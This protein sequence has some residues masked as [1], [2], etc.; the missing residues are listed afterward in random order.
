M[1]S[2][3]S[4]ALAALSACAAPIE[5]PAPQ[6]DAGALAPI[7]EDPRVFVA[8]PALLSRPLESQGDLMP[9]L[10]KEITN[11][12][13]RHGYEVLPTFKF[14]REWE[15]AE[16]RVRGTDERS[17]DALDEREFEACYRETVRALAANHSFTAVVFPVVDYES[18]DL[19]EP[20]R[21]ATWRGVRRKVK[22]EGAPPSEPRT[23][24]VAM[25]L[26]PRV[27][28]RSGVLAYESSIG[29]DIAEK[30]VE[31]DGEF[32]LVA[33]SNDEIDDRSIDECIDLVLGPLVDFGK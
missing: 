6:L 30:S 12:L 28:G 32:E 19:E 26:R 20:Y 7:A 2:L 4:L 27:V 17:S 31:R 11:Y 18:I 9:R 5:P 24:Y 1:R 22:F 14:E 8:P 15:R 33:K 13:E 25:S 3:L 23:R 21:E 29:L 10:R 16:A